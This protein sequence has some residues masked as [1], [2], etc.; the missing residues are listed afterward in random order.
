MCKGQNSI[1]CVDLSQGKP[2]NERL[3]DK[4]VSLSQ[5]LL[6]FTAL[7]NKKRTLKFKAQSAN[8]F[9]T[10][11]YQMFGGSSQLLTTAKH[12]VIKSLSTVQTTVLGSS[13]KLGGA[14]KHLIDGISKC[15]LG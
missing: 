1:H 12:V 15:I 11:V 6:N 4:L 13:Q 14:A 10:A 3:H 7:F 8:V 2:S 5:S 9:F